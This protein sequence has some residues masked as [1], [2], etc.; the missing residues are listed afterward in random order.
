M[1]NIWFIIFGLII[2]FFAFFLFSDGWNLSTLVKK[3]KQIVVIPIDT[4]PEQKDIALTQNNTIENITVSSKLPTEKSTHIV[5]EKHTEDTDVEDID[6]EAMQENSENK[7]KEKSI[8]KIKPNT[9]TT[10]A[11]DMS[12]AQEVKMKIKA[13]EK[14]GTVKAKVAISHAMLTYAQ[15]KKKGRETHF[16][17]HIQATVNKRVVYDASTSQFLSKNPLFKFSF[18]GK[19]GEILTVI[20]TQITGEV[21]YATKKIK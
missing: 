17:T 7:P 12:K 15:A 16:I 11:I 20:Y 13:K 1:K 9:S 5:E 19:K 10:V 18:R 14:Y 3:E 6:K 21:F 8:T 4:V 2:G